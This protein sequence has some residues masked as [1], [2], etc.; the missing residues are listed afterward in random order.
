MTSEILYLILAVLGSAG[1]VTSWNR[2]NLKAHVLGL[3]FPSLRDKPVEQV[4]DEIHVR[5]GT[6]GELLNCPY[7]LSAWVGLTLF[8]LF[9]L[10]GL[11]TALVVST[12]LV[13]AVLIAALET[14]PQYVPGE[15]VDTDVPAGNIKAYTP[16]GD[17]AFEAP[18]HIKQRILSIK[19]N[20]KEHRNLLTKNTSLLTLLQRP[21]DCPNNACREL[22]ENYQAELAHMLATNEKTPQKCPSCLRGSIVNKYFYMLYELLGPQ[23]TNH[24]NPKL[25]DAETSSPFI[26]TH[27]TISKDTPDK[28]Q[29]ATAVETRTA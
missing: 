23:Q 21:D 17:Y 25:N 20:P 12:F 5:W 7:C 8:G 26:P 28:E 2:T 3:F 9:S 22:V 13:P 24:L 6:L 27:D 15:Q 14:P 10:T 16:E 19:D 4:E 1:F 11:T 29:D 18:F